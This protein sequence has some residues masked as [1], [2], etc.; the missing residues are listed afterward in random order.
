[1]RSP[2]THCI[3]MHLLCEHSLSLEQVGV[4][5]HGGAR[6]MNTDLHPISQIHFYQESE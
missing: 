1:M 3:A 4:E 5:L 2:S 6:S